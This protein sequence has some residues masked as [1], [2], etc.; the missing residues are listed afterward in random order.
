MFTD[1]LRKF[2]REVVGDETQSVSH[3]AEAVPRGRPDSLGRRARILDARKHQRLRAACRPCR[4]RP[5]DAA[6]DDAAAA[7][8]HSRALAVRNGFLRRRLRQPARLGLAVSRALR[9]GADGRDLRQARRRP[10][11][12]STC[13][14][15][16]AS[17]RIASP[18]T[19]TTA[20]RSRRRSSTSAPRPSTCSAAK[21][22]GAAAICTSTSGTTRSGA[23]LHCNTSA[24]QSVTGR[25]VA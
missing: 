25:E 24:M 15:S 12:S 3:R 22:S 20:S 16:A 6:A 14:I 18:S 11:R 4:L 7:Q 2:S 19:T 9:L 17:T 5:A 21:P 1:D 23:G 8:R 10:T 13:S